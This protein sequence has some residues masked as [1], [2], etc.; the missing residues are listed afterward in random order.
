MIVTNVR[1]QLPG[2]RLFIARQQHRDWCIVRMELAIRQ[3]I[4]MKGFVHR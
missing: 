3:R 2:F 4:A 1:P